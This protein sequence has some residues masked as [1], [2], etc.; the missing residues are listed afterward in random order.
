MV[1]R[2]FSKD[3]PKW[4]RVLNMC[5]FLP[6]LLWP[7]VFYTTAFLFDNPKSLALAYLVFFGVNAYPVYLIVIA[8]LNILLFKKNII[9]GSILPTIMLLILVSGV[10]YIVTGM[11]QNYS[12]SLKRENDRRRQGYIGAN[13]DF[14]IINEKVYL[15]DTLIIGA[16]A[17]TFEIVSWNWQRDK[18]HYYYFGKK[19]E[20]IDRETFKDLD[21]HY[22]KDKFNVYYDDKVI[23]GADTRSFIHIEGTQDGKDANSCYRW[24]E[25]VDCKV[26]RVQ[27]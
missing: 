21:Y 1:K 16:D 10:A 24:G 12:Q 22:G 8:Y 9:I 4:F 15:R 19:V 18:N 14:K 11:T 13:N 26:L 25:K 6:A 5:L 3:I 20:C 7:I 17:K 2:L 23:K 27:E